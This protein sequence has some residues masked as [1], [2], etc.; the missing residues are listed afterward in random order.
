M[1]SKTNPKIRE[2]KTSLEINTD[3]V[4]KYWRKKNEKI[5]IGS[6]REM[7]ENS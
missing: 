1:D 2:I 4:W 5:K 7:L 3:T 6:D